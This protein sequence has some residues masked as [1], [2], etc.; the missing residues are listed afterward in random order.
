M[1][2]PDVQKPHCT[3]HSAA[4]ACWTGWDRSRDK[5]SM[6]VTKP[7]FQLP[8]THLATL[9]GPAIDVHDAEAA[10]SRV[11]PI[12]AAGEIGRVAKGPQQRRLRVQ[13]ILDRF[14]V[15]GKAHELPLG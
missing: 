6:V 1:I 7:A 13:P 11:A 8:D 9:H 12:F 3:A 4:Q 10:L 2:M 5:P 15:H 14:S